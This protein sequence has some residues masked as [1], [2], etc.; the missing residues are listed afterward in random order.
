M[1][2]IVPAVPRGETS[3]GETAIIALEAALD[4]SHVILQRCP[5]PG[6]LLAIHPDLGICAIA[7]AGGAS[8]WDADTGAWSGADPDAAARKAAKALGPLAAVPVAGV[9]F[10]PGTAAPAPGTP[11]SGL[12]AAFGPGA[13]AALPAMVA[14]AF[15]SSAPPGE[16]AVDALIQS[17]S[18]GAAPYARGWITGAQREWRAENTGKTSPAA[19]HADP[20]AAPSV[21]VPAIPAPP[22]PAQVTWLRV[23]GAAAR[24]TPPDGTAPSVAPDIT[25]D[26]PMVLLLRQAAETVT[27]ERDIIVQGIQISP[28]ELTE[29]DFLL[30]A[31][32]VAA[33]EEWAPVVVSKEGRGGFHLRLRSDRDGAILG[34]RLTAIEPSAPLLLMLPVVDRIRRSVRRLPDGREEIS[35][36]ETVWK[37]ARWLEANRLNTDV[38]GEIDVRIALQTS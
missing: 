11:G 14:A 12:P 26:D 24:P 3:A 35:M 31:L 22:D 1:A 38:I 6:L 15:G 20:N 8:L 17:V 23:D 19:P 9:A 33:A 29:P 7:C 2:R 30:P 27:G 16:A 34:Y 18:P 5:V 36:D 25:R 32:L 37:F 21:P 28:D 4:D 13:G 10:L